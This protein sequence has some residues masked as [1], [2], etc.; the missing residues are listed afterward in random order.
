MSAVFRLPAYLG[1]GLV[2]LYRYTLGV[3][4]PGGCKYH[5][6]CSQYAID[7][8]REYGLVRGVD[9]RRLAASALQ[10]VESRRGRLPRQQRLFK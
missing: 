1:V 3:L 7:A 8:L 2:Y 10:P 9:P 5:P 4:F 6:S